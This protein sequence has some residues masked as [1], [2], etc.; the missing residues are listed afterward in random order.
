MS[1][2][3]CLPW[4]V[5]CKQCNVTHFGLVGSIHVDWIASLVT[6]N[7]PS[8]H[9]EAHRMWTRELILTMNSFTINFTFIHHMDLRSARCLL[10]G[11]LPCTWGSWPGLVYSLVF[12]K[13]CPEYRSTL[14]IAA[15][16]LAWLWLASGS[17]RYYCWISPDVLHI[18]H[19]CHMGSLFM[20]GHVIVSAR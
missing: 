3:V 20:N 13:L 10:S 9:K 1:F 17:S 19:Q 12:L 18:G 11:F 2:M 15:G 7:V 16:D 14:C 4:E 5:N 8:T 6:G